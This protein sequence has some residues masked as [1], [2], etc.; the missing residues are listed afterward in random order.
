V[1]RVTRTGTLQREDRPTISYDV[2]GHG[3]LVVFV[4]GLT[5]FRQTWDPVTTLLAEE[6]TCVRLDLR[7]HGASSRTRS[8]V[9]HSFFQRSIMDVM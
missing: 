4:H 8:R 6:F 2:A 1:T 5:S 9:W 3:P 7:G